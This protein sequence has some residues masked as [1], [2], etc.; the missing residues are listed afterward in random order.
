MDSRRAWS[1][2]AALAHSCRFRTPAI[3]IAPGGAP[4]VHSCRFRTPAI[5]IAPGQRAARAQLPVPVTGNRDGAGA[6]RRSSTV[7]GF[8]HR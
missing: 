5:V 6:A 8:G 1:V 2:P 7:A 4:L 3:V